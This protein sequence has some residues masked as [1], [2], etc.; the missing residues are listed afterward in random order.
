M[1]VTRAFSPASIGKAYL[2]AMGIHPILERQPDFDPKVLGWAMSAFYGGRAECRIRK[3]A[4]PV[5][6]LDF[7]SMYPT[8]NALMATWE[9]VIA[10]RIAVDDVTAKVQK[11]LAVPDLFER[12]FSKSFWRQ[13]KCLVEIE[14][15]NDVLPVRAAYD[16]ASADYGIGVN[17]YRLAGSAWYPLG[18]VVA[19]AIFSGRVPPIRRALYLR[20]VGVQS[21][22]KPVAIWGSVQVDPTDG[23]FF[24]KAIELRHT[25]DDDPSLSKDE[26]DRLGPFLKVLANGA[27]YGI[28]AEFVRHESKDPVPVT[29]YADRNDPFETTTLAPEE[30]G[31]Y[32]FPPLAACIT[33][34]ARL[35]VALLERSVTDLGGSYVFCDTD[36]MGIVADASGGSYACPGGPEKL[37][38]SREA[39]RALSWAQV[40]GIVQRFATLNPYDRRAVP[41]SILKVEKENFEGGDPTRPRRQLCCWAISAKRYVLYTLGEGSPELVRATD[42]H[43]EALGD[44]LGLAKASQHGL[45]HLLNPLDPDDPSDDWVTEAWT[46]LLRK[47]LGLAAEE[48]RWL[49]RPALTRVTAS[50]PTVLRWFKGLNEGK[51]YAEQVKPANFLLLAHPDPL[52][53][54]GILPIAPYE[55]NASRWDDLEWIDRRNGQRIGIT[56][57]ALDGNERPGVVRVRT[58]GDVLA[59]YLAHPE[60]KSLGPEGEPVGRRTVGV[61]G[62]RP[63]EAAPPLRYVGKEGNK[64]DDRISGLVGEPSDYRTEYVDSHNDYWHQVVLPVL[65]AMDR[66]TLIEKSRLHR[67]TIERYLYGGVVPHPGNLALLTEIARKELPQETLGDGGRT[68]AVIPCG[69]A[70]SAIRSCQRS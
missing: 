26:R 28:L 57:D 63:V 37:P 55:S 56:T 51:G 30:P 41:G 4:L 53:P 10:R 7:V 48:P 45:G 31:P 23:D 61:L 62:R 54:S 34:A 29:V 59:S 20:G 36:S 24:C 18:D 16:P 66:K 9:L 69:R 13:L 27:S 39:V 11:L 2:K 33:G 70:D 58:Y 1:Q 65:A 14:P 44:E 21:G 32:C 8:I 5:I 64:L 50:S 19:S 49:N 47:A 12:C 38:D 35:M 17:P 42:D 15:D 25:L 52:D 22:L 43:E 6:Y 67:R 40:D 68:R 3:V 60:A 46:Y